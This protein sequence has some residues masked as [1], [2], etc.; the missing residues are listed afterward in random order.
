[1]NQLVDAVSGIVDSDER[2]QTLAATAWTVFFN[3]ASMT[4]MEIL[5]ATRVV[6]LTRPGAI[7]GAVSGTN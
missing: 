4:A 3:P 5:I 7:S 2:M 1:M 6:G